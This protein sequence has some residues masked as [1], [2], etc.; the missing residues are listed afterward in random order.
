MCE[1]NERYTY[2]HL[3]QKLYIND[4]YHILFSF[5][6]HE[7]CGSGMRLVRLIDDYDKTSCELRV[8]NPCYPGLPC[9]F[10]DEILAIII[11][12]IK[13]PRNELN[14][15]QI[16]CCLGTIHN[17][18]EDLIEEINNNLDPDE[19][20]NLE[21]TDNIWDNII[22]KK[23]LSPSERSCEYPKSLNRVYPFPTI[24]QRSKNKIGCIDGIKCKIDPVYGRI[25][26]DEGCCEINSVRSLG[27]L[28]N[29]KNKLTF[30]KFYKF[31]L[32]Q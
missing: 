32:I 3:E 19:E 10:N 16:I 13:N 22:Q 28:W 12:V 6:D 1:S 31:L 29:K 24:Y 25:I 30:A 14:L 4:Q 27:S 26:I 9:F 11:L 17:F 2:D 7:M 23:S 8:D 15:K 18:D 21:Q 20:I 5:Y